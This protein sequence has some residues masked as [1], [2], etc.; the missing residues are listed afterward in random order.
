MAEGFAGAR[1]L[2][3]RRRR[4][5]AG[6]SSTDVHVDYSTM[7]PAP[8]VAETTY[9]E[10]PQ[11]RFENRSDFPLARLISSRRWKLIGALI[12]VILINVGMA[13]FGQ[14]AAVRNGTYGQNISRIF[15]L[16]DGIAFTY[17]SS[18][19]L[20]GAAQLAFAIGW[21][22]S[23]NPRDFGG[24]YRIWRVAA[25]FL[26]IGA[27]CAT[28][29][30]HHA[31]A[32][33][34]AHYFPRRYPYREVLNWLVPLSVLSFPVVMKV[35][36]DMSNCRLSSALFSLT[37]VA[38]LL[39]AI[40]PIVD[41]WELTSSTL[42]IAQTAVCCMIFASLLVHAWF[43]LH[44]SSEPPGHS[45]GFNSSAANLS[46]NEDEF[47]LVAELPPPQ[48]EQPDT[49]AD[50][51]FDS[52]ADSIADPNI[53]TDFDQPPAN[54]PSP[55]KSART[56][57]SPRATKTASKKPAPKATPPKTAAENAETD[58]PASTAKAGQFGRIDGAHTNED[59]IQGSRKSSPK[60]S[61]KRK[62]K[63]RGK[64]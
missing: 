3:E 51:V 46:N 44:V 21:V 34:T 36:H 1:S 26:F 49:P 22:R 61:T 60:P 16:P 10:P 2:D 25:A 29:G 30:M 27:I 32:E 11:S 23:R 35:I 47:A 24:Y 20:I 54:K 15:L 37:T 43:V 5:I 31:V 12:G 18:L 28:T 33:L 64:K 56:T 9:S 14:S 17:F 55:V 48:N 53:S 41:R 19:M 57:K 42:I 39:V 6:E 58:K 45:S 62:R 59:L 40:A 52:I 38:A 8:M 7:A 4:R 50:S 63:T 13:L